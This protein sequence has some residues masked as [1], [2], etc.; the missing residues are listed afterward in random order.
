MD[1]LATSVET[2]RSGYLGWIVVLLVLTAFELLNPRGEQDLRSRVNGVAYWTVFIPLS[3]LLLT[4]LTWLWAALGIRPLLSLP[5]F[6]AFSWIG[7]LAAVCAVLAAAVAND[8]FFYWAHRFQHRFL[9]RYHAVHHS[10]REMNAVN[11]YHHASEA[12]VSLLLYT[13]PTSLIVSDMGPGLPFVGLAIWVHIVWIHSPTRANFG[14]LRAIFVDNRFHRI[15]HS[16]EER[17][18]DRNF[19]AFTTLWDRLFGTAYFPRA[20]EWPA[21]GLAD[22]DEPS[23]VREWID[24]PARYPIGERAGASS[25]AILEKAQA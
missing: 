14:P 6:H 2:A 12:I 9:W 20:G 3:A 5:A 13:V 21:V 22:I 23:G 10:I 8:F 25:T 24:L 18:F 1:F 4:A 16:L 17:H 15:H 7:P 11:S 19:G